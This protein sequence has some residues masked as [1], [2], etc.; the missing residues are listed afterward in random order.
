MANKAFI[1]FQTVGKNIAQQKESLLNF[2][3]Y[4]KY[5]RRAPF[6]GD[7][8]QIVTI[9]ARQQNFTYADFG[10]RVEMR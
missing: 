10:F 5:A 7:E 8:L 3:S 9:F 1:I 6:S 4:N 2:F